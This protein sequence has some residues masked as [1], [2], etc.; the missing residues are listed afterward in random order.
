MTITKLGTDLRVQVGLYLELM[1]ET[2]GGI[3]RNCIGLVENRL[4]E[5]SE[6]DNPS[7]SILLTT[8]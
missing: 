3:L 5:N 2:V 4:V 6:K 1:P 8:T 7:L